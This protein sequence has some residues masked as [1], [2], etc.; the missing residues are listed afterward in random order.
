ML[1]T[2]YRS[3]PRKISLFAIKEHSSPPPASP[4]ASRPTP[5]TTS[6]PPPRPP[7][8]PARPAPTSRWPA[9]PPAWTPPRGTTSVRPVP[10]PR[11]PASPA[12]TSR[13]LEPT[14]AWPQ[15]RGITCLAKD[16][17]SSSIVSQA[18][19]NR[20]Q[21]SRCAWTPHPDHTLPRM[22]LCLL[23]PVGWGHISPRVAKPP[24]C[25]RMQ[26]ITSIKSALIARR[27][28]PQAP[29]TRLRVR[30]PPLPVSR[31]ILETTLPNQL[32]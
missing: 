16:P 20:A 11:P 8:R 14:H 26:G 18:H 4:P 10:H 6:T 23:R 28:A 22:H 5:A 24:V 29:T 27:H 13:P 25:Y 7:S 17:L 19:I 15:I 9:S 1:G 2:M 21:A 32:R 3:R 12:P 30:F 31:Q